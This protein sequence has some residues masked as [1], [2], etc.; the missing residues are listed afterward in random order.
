MFKVTLIFALFITTFTQ[1]PA[2]I[3]P[4]NQQMIKGF[5]DGSKLG[6]LI[7]DLSGCTA[8]SKLI[9]DA[10]LAA[11]ETFQKTPLLLED[12]AS[13]V[14]NIGIAI[15]QFGI[16]AKKCS[17]IPINFLHV[18]KYLKALFDSPSAYISGVKSN[19]ILNV[20][21]LIGDLWQI[22]S[23]YSESKYYEFGKN[24]GTIANLVL[25][26]DFPASGHELKF[27]N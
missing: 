1:S 8:D 3:S 15:E 7:P 5:L 14:M 12:V 25:Y 10:I 11:V 20:F 17:S 4:E 13:G 22:N 19:I 27:L 6:I 16:A 23:L 9:A 2:T 24:I 18:L 21:A 26:V